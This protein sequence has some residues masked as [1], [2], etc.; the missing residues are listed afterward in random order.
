MKDYSD[1]IEEL[2]RAVDIRDVKFSTQFRDNPDGGDPIPED[3]FEWTVVGE[4]YN[5]VTQGRIK[6]LMPTQKH[7]FG[8][9]EWA[10]VEPL[11]T[12]WK[13][14][15]EAPI[16]GTPIETWNGFSRD[17]AAHLERTFSIRTLEQV[18]A[19]SDGQM[20]RCQI[21]DIRNRI[22]AIVLFLD[23]NRNSAQIERG[24]EERDSIIQAQAK[25]LEEM[26]AQLAALTESKGR[27]PGR[28]R[29][30]EAA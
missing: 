7:P 5:A 14:N 8:S 1:Q 20:A 30:E 17:E 27:G 2:S 21:Q 13:A 9:L 15:R 25:K 3:Y 6:S 28:P 4:N 26:Q 24:F 18:A 22:K 29:K 12:A 10:K 23:A 19:M 16:D 11:Y